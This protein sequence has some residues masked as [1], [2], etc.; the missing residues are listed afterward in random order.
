MFFVTV[1]MDCRAGCRMYTLSDGVAGVG[2]GV[3]AASGEAPGEDE[4]AGAAEGTP[5]II[6]SVPL[7]LSAV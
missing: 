4:A 7:A 3:G 6:N 1:K 5:P 2:A